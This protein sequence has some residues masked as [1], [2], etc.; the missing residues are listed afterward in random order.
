MAL[1][2]GDDKGITVCMQAV[3][4]GVEPCNGQGLHN[5]KCWHGSGACQDLLISEVKVSS[6]AGVIGC[7]CLPAKEKMYRGSPW[8][9]VGVWEAVLDFGVSK[10]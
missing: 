6:V 3:D 5:G 7:F 10:R 8:G 2:N 1:S 4:S 9:A